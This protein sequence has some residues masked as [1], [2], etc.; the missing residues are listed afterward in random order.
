MLVQ[1]LVSGSLEFT[2]DEFLR[3]VEPLH[4]SEILEAL[5][6]ADAILTELNKSPLGKELL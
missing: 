5:E 3:L 4:I 2:S 6:E 1:R